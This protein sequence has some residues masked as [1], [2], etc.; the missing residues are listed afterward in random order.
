[1]N[2]GHILVLLAISAAVVFVLYT[3]LMRGLHYAGADGLPGGSSVFGWIAKSGVTAIAAVV[4]AFFF[5]AVSSYIVGLVG[6]SN[7]PVSGMTICTVL[8]VSGLMLLMGLK[9]SSGILAT[10][11]VAGVVCCAACA[12][13]DMS[14]DL[15]TGYL[16]GATPSLQQWG[17]LIGVVVPAALIPIVMTILHG[18]FGIGVEVKE[19]VEFLKAPQ[20]TLFAT[21]AQ[22]FFSDGHLPWNMVFYGAVIGVAIIILDE[23]L[24]SGG[25]SFRA[26]VMPVAVGIYL[27]LS[28]SVPIFLG[29]VLAAIVGRVASRQG[30]DTKRDALHRGTILGSGLIAGEALTGIGLGAYVFFA[31]KELPVKLPIGDV[32]GNVLSVVAMLL[33]GLAIYQI[34]MRGKKA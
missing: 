8:L 16:V 19:G 33:V 32:T 30:E 28:L 22:A 29:G 2:F 10:L 15:K 34:A 11:G 5:V 26:Y 7:N 23:I 1:M 13:G 14:Q 20:A 24:R 21:I 4:A 12:A 3:F 25:S 9:G 27:P 18:S 6:S 17:E 31:Q